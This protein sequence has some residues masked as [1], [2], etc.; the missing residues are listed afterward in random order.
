LLTVAGFGVI[1]VLV[2][3]VVTVSFDMPE[4]VLWI[5]SPEK[6]AVIVKVPA[7]AGGLY[8]MAHLPVLVEV[9]NCAN[10]HE[11][12]LKL[13]PAPPSLHDTV[14]VGMLFVPT[15]ESRTLA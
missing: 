1:V 14:P 10:V 13:P 3:S 11:V 12:A 2:G 8:T 6:V 15:L 5:A 4:L 9:P 7:F